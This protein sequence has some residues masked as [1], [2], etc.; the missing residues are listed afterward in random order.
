M[1]V[2]WMV[3]GS[4]E[5]FLGFYSLLPYYYWYQR[6]TIFWT[7]SMNFER[8]A[9]LPHRL[10]LI[11]SISIFLVSCYLRWLFV[12]L[13]LNLSPNVTTSIYRQDNRLELSSSTS[14]SIYWILFKTPESKLATRRSKDRG[15]AFHF[16]T[17]S[18]FPLQFSDNSRNL[19]A[20]TQSSE[21][22]FVEQSHSL[23]PPSISNL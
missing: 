21:L 6:D 20:L 22:H 15:F 11:L 2:R 23:G 13:N 17:V 16:F 4:S 8:V 5:W 7:K 3:F 10:L 14:L 1:R 9:S 18:N 12:N 19:S